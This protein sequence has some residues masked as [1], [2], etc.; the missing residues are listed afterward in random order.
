MIQFCRILSKFFHVCLCSL[1]IAVILYLDECL[2]IMLLIWLSWNS[3]WENRKIEM[4]EGSKNDCG[5]WEWVNK[6]S[7]LWDYLYICVFIF[8]VFWSLICSQNNDGWKPYISLLF[9]VVTCS[10][11][12]RYVIHIARVI[13]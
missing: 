13:A 2:H 6:S 11:W 10:V 5:H 12:Q 8:Y 1:E 9:W 7:L 4:L 3:C